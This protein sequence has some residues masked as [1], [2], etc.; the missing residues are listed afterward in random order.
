MLALGSN[1]PPREGH[2]DGAVHFLRAAGV[3]VLGTAPRWS[4]SPLAAPPQPDFLN[5]V[6][7]VAAPLDAEGWLNLAKRAESRAE[8]V[9]SVPRGPRRLDV[10]V[11]LVEGAFRSDPELTLPHPG[12][13]ERPYLIR[14]T[15][16]LVPGWELPGWDTDLSRL[17]GERLQGP[18]AIRGAAGPPAPGSP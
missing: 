1:L 3:E 14:G 9:R 8:R 11:I 13:R 4:T 7:L 18:W 16:L 5:Q 15:F 12:L 6:L 17:A 10:D 2:L